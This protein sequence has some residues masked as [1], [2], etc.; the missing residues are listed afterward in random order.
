MG[1]DRQAREMNP[2]QTALYDLHREAG[3]RM[4]DFAGYE[5]PLRYE[6]GTISE[7]LHTRSEASLFDVSHMGVIEIRGKDRAEALEELVP[8]DIQ[9]LAPD[10]LRYTFLTNR[11]GGIIDDLI[12]RNGGDRLILVA[13][14]ARKHDD[15]AHLVANLTGD[16][17]AVAQDESQILALQGPRSAMALGRLQPV[18]T[19]LGFMHGSAGRIAGADVIFSRS[20]YT[21]EDGFELIAPAEE[22]PGLA[23]ALIEQPE[24][25]W[26]GLGARDTLR[27]EAGLCLYGADLDETTSPVEAGLTWAMQKRRREDGGFLG[28]ET[29]ADQLARGPQRK[30]VGI[31][32]QGRAPV[33]EGGVL[34]D[35]Q[36]G[37]TVGGVTSGGYGPSVEGP[38][39]MGYV[40][41]AFSKPGTDLLAEIRGKEIPCRTEELPFVPHRYWKGKP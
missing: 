31:R 33:R 29:I 11:N 16:A 6:A 39:A 38:V 34:A 9:G 20:G 22:A 18:A 13:N 7:H 30:R 27:L 19:G 8:S 10:R 32:P 36:D 26:A 17:E 23:T 14:A 1:R 28:W 3:A 41:A 37:R 25:S 4:I 15:L 21:G 2:L 40:E 12:V 35:P 24:V 5:M